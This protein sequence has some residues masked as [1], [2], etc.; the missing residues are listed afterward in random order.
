MAG[1]TQTAAP[2]TGAQG[3]ITV[4]KTAENAAAT[5]NPH[6]AVTEAA[7][8]EGP[9]SGLPQFEFQHWGGQIAYLL[10]LFAILY[11]LMSRVFAPRI[12]KIF[13]ER[14]KTIGGA[15]ASA[16]QV[17]AE[18]AAQAEAARQALGEAR[19]TAQKTAADAKA[20]ADAEAKAQKDALEAELATKLAAAEASIRA[21]RD[22]AMGNVGAVATDTAKAIVEKLT[23]APAPA[24]AV[25]AVLAKQG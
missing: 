19:A 24:G 14:E 7:E 1:Q 3:A 13:D 12:R 20:K 18:A 9:S 11:V 21:A 15:I 5:A 10:I 6:H 4:E 25:E 23:G 2:Q 16:K 22:A 8:G 17:Q